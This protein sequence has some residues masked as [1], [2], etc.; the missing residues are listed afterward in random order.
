MDAFDRK[1]TP[2]THPFTEP[3]ILTFL[4]LRIARMQNNTSYLSRD[5]SREV[6]FWKN[7]GTAT[8]TRKL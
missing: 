3:K 5:L 1:H 2:I 4:I 6:G 7:H 8:A